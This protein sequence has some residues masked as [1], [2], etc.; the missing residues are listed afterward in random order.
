MNRRIIKETLANG[1][2]QY[3]VEVYKRPTIFSKKQWYTDS[4]NL[5]E[6]TF[7]AI[8]KTLEEAQVHCGIDTN[9]VVSR[10]IIT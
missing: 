10:E 1:D 4:F 2:I 6:I 7:S 8:F 9:P 3:R 5:G